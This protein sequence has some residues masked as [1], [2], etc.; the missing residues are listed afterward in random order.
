MSMTEVFMQTT[1]EPS[2]TITMATRLAG[3]SIV[4]NPWV[5]PT[6]TTMQLDIKHWIS[7]TVPKPRNSDFPTRPMTWIG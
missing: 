3:A 4:S 7:G 5:L 6:G 1:L 2:A